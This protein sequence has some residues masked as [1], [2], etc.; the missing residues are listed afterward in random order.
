[1]MARASGRRRA[2]QLDHVEA[3][4]VLEPHVDDGEGGVR[5]L[6]LLPRLGHGFGR[7]GDEA[8]LLHGAGE[9]LQEGLVVVDDE[10]DVAHSRRRGAAPLG[11]GLRAFKHIRCPSH[12]DCC[13]GS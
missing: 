8:A 7:L 9:A 1:M 3:V 4:A 10:K 12:D 13:C 6:R 11:H 5:R 2:D